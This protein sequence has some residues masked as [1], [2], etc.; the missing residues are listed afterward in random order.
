MQITTRRPVVTTIRAP[1]MRHPRVITWSRR[2]TTQMVPRSIISDPWPSLGSSS[3]IHTLITA[4]QTVAQELGS[5][6]G[7]GQGLG[8]PLPIPTATRAWLQVTATRFTRLNLKRLYR[9]TPPVPRAP[10]R[11]PPP[12]FIHTFTHTLIIISWRTWLSSILRFFIRRLMAWLPELSG[13]LTPQ[14]N[15]RSRRIIH[16]VD[17]QCSNFSSVLVVVV[18]V[19]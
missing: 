18:I 2:R 17:S 11:P 16:T 7:Q 8:T 14:R 9:P 3:A 15:R 6:P 5:G 12:S 4:L 1:R 10:S 19:I 13:F